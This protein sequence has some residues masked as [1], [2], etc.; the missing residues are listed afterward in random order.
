MYQ[1]LPYYLAYPMMF[2]N[3]EETKELQDY[4]YMKSMYPATARRIYPYIER[5]CDRLEYNCSMMYDEYPDRLQLDLLIKQIYDKVKGTENNPGEW[6]K[7]LIQVMLCQE[8]YKRRSEQR[9]Y[10]RRYF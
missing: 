3:D 9:T 8:I 1:K 10:R 6:L 2:V 5:A 7:D 4:E